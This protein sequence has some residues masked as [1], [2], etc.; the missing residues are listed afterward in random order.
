MCHQHGFNHQQSEYEIASKNGNHEC[1]Q[2]LFD[3]KVPYPI[4]INY[5]DDEEELEL[6]QTD[7]YEVAV[8]KGHVECLKC[9]L[10]NKAPRRDND[11][12][13]SVAIRNGN[14][15]CLT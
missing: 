5:D 14:L 11:D 1:L 8:E 2:F 10:K 6:F 3:N 13:I 4:I 9:L 12:L 15:D 7:P